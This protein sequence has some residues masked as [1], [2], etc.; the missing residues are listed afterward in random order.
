[1]LI[2]F[3]LADK[4]FGINMSDV[5]SIQSVTAVNSGQNDNVKDTVTIDN[6]T[7]PFCDIS[8]LTGTN[9]TS[10][11]SSKRVIIAN[12]KKGTLALMAD[13]VDGVFTAQKELITPLPSICND[14]ALSC[15]PYVL[16]H[17]N[18]LVLLLNPDGIAKIQTLTQENRERSGDAQLQG[19]N[20]QT[21]IEEPNRP[22]NGS[23]YVTEH[24]AYEEDVP[25]DLGELTDS[26]SINIDDVIS[27]PIQ[28][29][30][31]IAVETAGSQD[32]VTTPKDTS[33]TGMVEDFSTDNNGELTTKKSSFIFTS[34]NRLLEVENNAEANS[35]PPTNE[36]KTLPEN[37]KDISD[38]SLC[39][40]S[41]I[42]K[43]LPY[44][45][46]NEATGPFEKGGALVTGESSVTT[47]EQDQSLEFDEDEI[48]K[49]LPEYSSQGSGPVRTQGKYEVLVE[50]AFFDDQVAG[51]STAPYEEA[52]DD[53]SDII[54]YLVGDGTDIGQPK[55]DTFKDSKSHYIR[56][57]TLAGKETISKA[58]SGNGLKEFVEETNKIYKEIPK[59]STEEDL[60]E[61]IDELQE[62]KSVQT[63][64]EIPVIDGNAESNFEHFPIEEPLV[65]I[66][67][68]E[69]IDSY[70]YGTPVV[71]DEKVAQD[72]IDDNASRLHENSNDPTLFSNIKRSFG[73]LS[74]YFKSSSQKKQAVK[75]RKLVD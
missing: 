52:V 1:M 22:E 35:S 3:Q 75:R 74:R 65:H 63:S 43:L 36:S 2:L 20:E 4:K 17:K 61:F 50:T 58:N 19:N 60:S 48:G 14:M 29:K 11:S 31:E 16:R 5:K 72:D 33:P 42:H 62:G 12:S 70:D 40:S 24:D 54:N 28:E 59:I 44:N 23:E 30:T 8:V 37:Q 45:S 55:C 68:P 15:F 66:D 51:E 41:Q 71:S 39:Q 26:P 49:V 25:A 67:D 64:T 69:T 53:F 6:E 13:K 47:V 46:K 21:L 56:K 9:S 18:D 73:G 57:P 34:A 7:M 27:A 10:K 38:I 32:T